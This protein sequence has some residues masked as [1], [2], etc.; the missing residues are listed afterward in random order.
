MSLRYVINEGFAGFSRARLAA[1]TSVVAL[2]VA[3]L[4][5]SVLARFSFNAFE[6]AQDLRSVI[7]VEVFLMDISDERQQQLQVAFQ[8]LDI[9]D[10]VNYISKDSA[11]AIFQEEFGAEGEGLADLQFLPA[12]FQLDISDQASAEQIRETVESIETY[13]GVDEVVFNQQLLQMLEDR[14]QTVM[15]AGG[16]VGLL[17][18][19]TAIVL[20]FNTIRLTIYAKRNL[21]KAMKLVGAT[22]GFIRRPFMVE[23]ML[24]GV[25]AGLISA[26]MHWLLFHLVIPANIPQLGVMSWPWGEWYY[27]TGAMILLAIMMGFF[28]SRWAARKFIREEILATQ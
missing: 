24:Q 10:Q 25:L 2:T 22:N 5:L 12:S 11:A 13:G 23:G 7:E 17:I 16:G 4:L 26:G 28:G 20:V 9:V 3:V 14:M 27:L 19:F 18:F 6:V 1:F 15:L 8:E 21:I